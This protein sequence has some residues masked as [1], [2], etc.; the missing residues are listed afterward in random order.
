[1]NSWL[2]STIDWISGAEALPDML[3]DVYE[4][5]LF[6]DSDNVAI[7]FFQELPSTGITI[8]KYSLKQLAAGLN[9]LVKDPTK[10]KEAIDATLAIP[11]PLIKM[12]P[13]PDYGDVMTL[14]TFTNNCNNGFF[15]N[16][17]G[18]GNLSDGK[19]MYGEEIRPS[20]V[21]M[22]NKFDPK[23]THVVWFNK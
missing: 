12:Y 4:A 6:G 9:V 7:N 2:K 19:V 18:H 5:I 11:R 22:G 16:S 8:K 17:D 23:Y 20:H 1:M 15:V 21:K 3:I 10:M 14:E 13:L